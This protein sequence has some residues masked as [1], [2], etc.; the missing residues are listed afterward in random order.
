MN[1]SKAPQIAIVLAH[2]ADGTSTVQTLDGLSTYCARGQLVAVAGHALVRDG[3]V[4]E[5]RRPKGHPGIP[6]L[7]ATK[8][9]SVRCYQ[10]DA[11][12]PVKEVVTKA[13]R[14]E[15]I[16]N[17]FDALELIPRAYSLS[18][19]S[20]FCGQRGTGGAVLTRLDVMAAVAASRLGAGDIGPELLL[21]YA[22]VC[23][24][25]DQINRDVIIERIRQHVACELVA[26]VF[27][28]T[29]AHAAAIHAYGALIYS[30]RQPRDDVAHQLCVR[31]GRYRVH[32]QIA[33]DY[34]NTSLNRAI[35]RFK[36]KIRAK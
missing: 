34:A 23:G 35:A 18:S 16:S 1:D 3:A 24:G 6:T 11:R 25:L 21:D 32:A 33:D 14:I 17:T 9:R 15:A 31:A 30:M 28:E 7:S 22:R 20:D 27:S 2:N 4:V 5:Q 26:P 36:M 29:C 13:K 12:M 19:V 8:N 10:G